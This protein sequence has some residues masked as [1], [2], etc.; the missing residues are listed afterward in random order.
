[1]SENPR[2]EHDHL[3]N[4]RI[5]ILGQVFCYPRT[6]W[7]AASIALVVS[8]ICTIV[9]LVLNHP[10]DVGE[11]G[12]LFFVSRATPQDVE[13]DARY[14]VQ[15]W[16]PSAKTKEAD[17]AVDWE[18][19][20][21][22]DKLDDFADQLVKS[23]NGKVRGYRRYEVIGAGLSHSKAGYWWVVTVDNDYKVSDLLAFYHYFW[24]N[25]EAVYIEVLRSR[26]SSRYE[27]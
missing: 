11:L 16:T 26:V 14:L 12:R 27:K 4:D 7:G 20:D 1:M 17:D 25:P 18:K 6:V 8:G 5:E 2:F 24:K 9:W 19:F 13:A 21:S 23:S 10:K 3:A 15:F 22:N